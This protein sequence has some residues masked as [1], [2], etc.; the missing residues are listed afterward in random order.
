[1]EGHV[2][3]LPFKGSRDYLHSTDIYP[4]LMELVREH[5]GSDAWVDALCLRRPFRNWVLASF[6]NSVSA[7]GS[8]RVRNQSVTIAGSLYETETPVTRGRPFDTS[9]VAA[10][11]E[12]ES[13]SAKIVHPTPGVTPLE[14][15]VVLM[16]RLASEVN[17]GQWWFCQMN[18]DAPLSDQYPLQVRITR[19]IGNNFL[20][21]ELSQANSPIGSARIMFD[22]EAS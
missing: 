8:F 18:L 2:L 6:E 7:T 22:R 10:S 12:I 17:A 19:N 5:I 1:M 11:A 3:D 20:I 21:Y 16:K 9:V 13:G 4:A 14:A 15:F